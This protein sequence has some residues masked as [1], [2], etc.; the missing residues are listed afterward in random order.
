MAFAA[1]LLSCIWVTMAKSNDSVNWVSTYFKVD[2]DDI[3]NMDLY[4]Y[5]FYF[6]ATLL[7]QCYGDIVATNQGER[8]V[9]VFILFCGVIVYAVAAGSLSSI[10]SEY[11]MSQEG[12]LKKLNILKFI[13]KQ[14]NL[15][16]QLLSEIEWNIDFEYENHVE[17]IGEF[18]EGMPLHLQE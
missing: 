3:K 15:S 8:L 2:V 13:N 10:I 6:A 1:H 14:H 18:M 4:I 7:L 12:K 9:G 5:A 17:G 16:S 11:D